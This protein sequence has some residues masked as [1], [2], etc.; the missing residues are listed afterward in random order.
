MIR[1][2]AIQNFQ[3]HKQ[4]ELEFKEGMNVIAGSSDN[5]KSSIIRAIRWVLMNRPTGFA[6]HTHGAKDDTAV[7]MV[8]EDYEC[9]TRQKGEKN[10]GG[11]HHRGKTYAALRTDVPPEIQEVLNLSDINIQ[12]QHDPYFLLQDSPGEVA[13]KLN[14]IAGLGVIG[15]TIKRA[16]AVVRERKDAV[17]NFI[18]QEASHKAMFDKYS[19]AYEQEDNVFQIKLELLNY[20]RLE[21]TVVELK[22]NLERYNSL[23]VVKKAGI[24]RLAEYKAEYEELKQELEKLNQVGCRIA[25]LSSLIDRF[26]VKS[27]GIKLS[28]ALA[29]KRASFEAVRDMA[30]DYIKN[31]N[32]GE[33][34]KTLCKRHFSVVLERNKAKRQLESGKEELEVFKIEY[35]LCP[36]C[37]RPWE[38]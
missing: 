23:L 2:V 15:E 5:G 11:Y 30:Q 18:Q 12:S 29:E 32:V 1:K 26:R 21:D 37:N 14:M 25:E 13:K 20:K 17:G 16:N 4:T 19:W 35:P 3:I 7:A 6:F 28:K 10:S 33:D 38:E 27:K 8:F 9:V 24:D 22:Q 31:V 34:L 36:T